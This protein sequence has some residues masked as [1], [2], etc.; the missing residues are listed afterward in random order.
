MDGEIAT[1][2]SIVAR[3]IASRRLMPVPP[4]ES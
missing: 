1:P 4:L 3:L 2:S